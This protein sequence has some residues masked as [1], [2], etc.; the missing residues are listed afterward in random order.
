MG[1]STSPLTTCAGVRLAAS[2]NRPACSL[3]PRSA[4]RASNRN[5]RWLVMIP[6]SWSRGASVAGVSPDSTVNSI[7]VESPPGVAVRASPRSSRTR[8][9][10]NPIRR[11][12]GLSSASGTIARRAIGRATVNRASITSAASTSRNRTKRSEPDHAAAAIAVP[13]VAALVA[14]ATAVAAGALVA[15]LVR[16]GAH[17]HVIARATPAP[18]AHRVSSGSPS[19]TPGAGS[20]GRTAAAPMASPPRVELV[21]QDDARGLAIDSRPERRSLRLRRGS[22]RSP[23]RHAPEPALGLERGQALVAHRDREAEALPD[24]ARPGAGRRRHLALGAAGVDG[25]PDDQLHHALVAAHAADR[26]GV[27][28]DR[29]GAP[30]RRE[31]AGDPDAGVGDGE[32]DA[33]RPEVDAQHAAHH[34]RSPVAG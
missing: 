13:V 29:G 8:S 21:L 34:G 26:L 22:A 1:L 27:L 24:R 30:D 3:E 25:E 7:S 19:A 17:R 28:L 18:D 4:I 16:A 12:D 20:T 23:A 15:V 33:L 32:A 9:A 2:P 10:T 31:G 11:A 14:R 6:A 5:A